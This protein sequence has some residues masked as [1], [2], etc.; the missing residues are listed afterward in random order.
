MDM[1]GT[2][3]AAENEFAGMRLKSVFQG[4]HDLQAQ[5]VVGHSAWIRPSR[6]GEAVPADELFDP[7]RSDADIVRIDRLCRLMHAASYHGP[8]PRETRLIV[9]VHPR[10]LETVTADHGRA[11]REA[12]D[13][14]GLG[15][16][17][18]VICLPDPSHLR[19]MSLGY[20]IG[21]YR[22]HGFE[23]A[24]R[25]REAAMLPDLLA[26]TRP[27]LVLLD[28][29]QFPGPKAAGAVKAAARA[30]SQ[31]VFIKIES[32]ETLAQ[33][34]AAGGTLAQGYHLDAPTEI[35]GGAFS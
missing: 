22:L 9:P 24:V 1:P 28:I 23:I 34:R 2:R 6:D 11:Y 31:P 3:M 17:K 8:A 19:T 30:G 10:L 14:M 13:G 16:A 32:A 27:N 25:L 21:S 12:L 26:R 4:L 29:A 35:P 33:V 20:L 7:A 18:V 15:A 5:A